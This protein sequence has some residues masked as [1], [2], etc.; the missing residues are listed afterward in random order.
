MVFSQEQ[1]VSIVEFYFRTL[2]CCE[3]RNLFSN[4]Y[5]TISPPSNE[6]IR[7]IVQKFK[8]TG[9][10]NDREKKRAKTV[11]TNECVDDIRD[12]ISAAPNTSV[13]K[14]STQ[15]NI[16]YGSV[17]NA[18]K[19]SLHY[20][21]YKINVIQ[22]LK[23][24]DYAKRLNYCNWFLSFIQNNPDIL[25]LVYFTDEAYFHLNGYVNSQNYRTWASENPHQFIET[26]LFPEK[27]GVWCA[28]S[29]KR[30]IGPIYF[31]E[32]LNSDRYTDILTAFI[33]LLE[34]N[35]RFCWLQQD[36][37]PHTGA[38]ADKN[39]KYKGCIFK[40]FFWFFMRK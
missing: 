38:N 30:I 14:L 32:P 15:C 4:R 20:H 19:K 18:L 22:E 16:S 39:Q 17:R 3:V 40:I 31:S 34:E 26:P 28:I 6:A 2:S 11:L 13:R 29:K 35:E 25:D 37:A 5:S 33:S 21:P 7:N 36:G 9:S 10:I 24:A 12:K 27:V 23:P 1:R 8:E